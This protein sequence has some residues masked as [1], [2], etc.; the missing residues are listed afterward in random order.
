MG[1]TAQLLMLD[2]GC[3]DIF[4]I[5]YTEVLEFA[6]LAASEDDLY[7][8][9]CLKTGVCARVCVRV[10]ENKFLVYVSPC[11]SIPFTSS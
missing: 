1:I 6:V 7:M 9:H 5:L 8:T 10:D 3:V 2:N 4:N 11:V